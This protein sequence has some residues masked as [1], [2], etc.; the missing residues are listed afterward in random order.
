MQMVDRT[1]GCRVLYTDT[2][3]VVFRH[4]KGVNPIPE[5]EFLG[6][7]SREYADFRI[8]RFVAAGPKQWGLEMVDKKLGEKKWVLKL[9]GITLDHGYTYLIIKFKKTLFRQREE[10]SIQHLRKNGQGFWAGQ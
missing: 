6:E 8:D 2:D 7:M 9:R 10:H 1:K 3:S 5:G 4:P